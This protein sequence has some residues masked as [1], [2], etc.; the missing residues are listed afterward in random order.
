MDSNASDIRQH[1]HMLTPEQ[2]SLRWRSEVVAK[3]SI[4]E[5][6]KLLTAPAQQLASVRLP[7]SARRFLAEAGLPK[8]CA[9]FLGFEEV[10]KGLPRIWERYSPG[11]WRPEEKAGLE[12]YLLI[13]YDDEAGNPI[14]VDERDGRVFVVEPE[15]LKAFERV[16]PPAVAKG[17]FWSREAA[18]ARENE[19][20]GNDH[21][22]KKPWWRFW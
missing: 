17:A 4:P 8:G 9:P 16:D 12:H 14:C 3:D 5:D 10:G 1:R 20:E 7:E 18:A 19:K 11:Q 2:F 21:G 22:R 15:R 13:G 6:V